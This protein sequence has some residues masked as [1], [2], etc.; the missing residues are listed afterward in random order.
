M[1]FLC[2]C[3]RRLPRRFPPRLP[4]SGPGAS[5]LRSLSQRWAAGSARPA[6]PCCLHQCWSFTKKPSTGKKIKGLKAAEG[7]ELGGRGLGGDG[8]RTA[9]VLAS[10][11]MLGVG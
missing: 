2:V 6:A 10:R 9:W 7:A 11:V 4:G 1:K 5:R 3:G 8:L